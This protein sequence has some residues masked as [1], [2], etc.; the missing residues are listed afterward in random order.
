MVN[1]TAFV[2]WQAVKIILKEFSLAN[3][4]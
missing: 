1:S 3:E 4:V 2:G